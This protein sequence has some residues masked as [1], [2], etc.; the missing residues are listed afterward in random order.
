M[1][2]HKK[3]LLLLMFGV[4]IGCSSEVGNSIDNSGNPEPP[5]QNYTP[6]E[7]VRNFDTGNAGEK[8]ERTADGFDDIAGRSLYDK[9]TFYKGSGS[10]KLHILNNTEGFGTWGGAIKFPQNIGEGQHLYMSLAIKI[11]KEFIVE[12][13]GNGSLKF[14]R[15]ASETKLDDGSKKGTGYIDIQI[16]DDD[17]QNKPNET[18]FRMLRE[19]QAVWYH[20]GETN[21][22]TRDIWHKLDFYINFDVAENG[23]RVVI[24]LNGK[25]ITDE[26]RMKTLLSEGNYFHSLYLFTYWNGFAPQDQHLWI[27]EI[28]MSTG[29]PDW[30]LETFN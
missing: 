3:W 7:L 4:L 20:F 2:K 13:P 6:W 19:H 29:Y 24:W 11:S 10:A 15:F 26:T 9:T 28:K 8:A 17:L 14:I 23:S 30:R 16:K 27:D 21:S 5:V 12:T 25:K 1:K 22:I 18:S